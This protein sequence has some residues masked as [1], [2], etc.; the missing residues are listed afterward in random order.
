MRRRT[1]IVQLA[2]FGIISV[3]IVGFTLFSLLGI[4]LTNK[5]FHV[6]V[7]L[8]RGGGI[9]SGA[10]VAYRGVAVGQRQR[11]PAR[12]RAGDP[13][14]RDQARHPHSG[15]RRQLTSTTCRR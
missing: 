13:H 9:F 10:E 3:L 5:P 4:S 11:R 2:V 15:G 12:R 8:S 6:T 7:R 14:A 1:V